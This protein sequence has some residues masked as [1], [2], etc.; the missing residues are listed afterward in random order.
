MI[1]PKATSPSA[2][3]INRWYSMGATDSRCRPRRLGADVASDAVSVANGNLPGD[4]AE[5]VAAVLVVAELVERR[6]GGREQHGVARRGITRRLGD[7]GRQVAAVAVRDA[8]L[9][10]LGGDRAGGLA[11][12]VDA[13]DRAVGDRGGQ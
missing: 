8:L 1:R 3:S 4:P 11:D 10:E 2:T 5:L 9:V 12:Q 13:G 7:G 6:A